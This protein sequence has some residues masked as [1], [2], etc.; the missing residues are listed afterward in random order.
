MQRHI[1]LIS[2]SDQ[3][4]L[5]C[6]PLFRICEQHHE[7]GWKTLYLHFSFN[8]LVNLP[9]HKRATVYGNPVFTFQRNK[10]VSHSG[11]TIW[12]FHQQLEEFQFPHI[13][14][15]IYFPSLPAFGNSCPNGQLGIPL[16]FKF[17]LP[18]LVDKEHTCIL[19]EFFGGKPVLLPPPSPA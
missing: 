6:F 7:C 17:I 12:H 14:A 19:Y 10:P 3:R 1:V 16:W 5:N 11:C 13:L 8:L 9:R 15:N 18:Q 2:Y 4:H